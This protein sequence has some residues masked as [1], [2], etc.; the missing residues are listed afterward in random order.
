MPASQRRPHRIANSEAPM[1]MNRGG[2]ARSHA[3]RCG[4]KRS[5]NACQSK[6]R[7]Y[8]TRTGVNVTS[9]HRL[10]IEWKTNARET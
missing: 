3:T 4:H 6:K 1:R 2:V 10:L 7:P 9:S 8:T 5:R